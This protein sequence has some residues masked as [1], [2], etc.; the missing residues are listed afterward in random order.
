MLIDWA[1][2]DVHC[3]VLVSY[4]PLEKPM[5]TT[6]VKNVGLSNGLA[7]NEKTGKMYYADSLKHAVTEYSYDSKTGN[8]GKYLYMLIFYA[9]FTTHEFL[10]ND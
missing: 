3:G 2:S 8:I 5:L 7:W 9:V 1:S 10:N 4:S 6:R